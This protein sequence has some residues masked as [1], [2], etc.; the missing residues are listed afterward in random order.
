MAIDA[1][2]LETLSALAKKVRREYGGATGSMEGELGPLCN[3]MV[4]RLNRR[5][6]TAQRPK[7]VVEP[8]DAYP[9]LLRARRWRGGCVWRWRQR[10]AQ[11]LRERCVGQRCVER[12]RDGRLERLGGERNVVER[13]EPD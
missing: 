12:R 3:P 8:D 13:H 4:S 1:A 7:R 10:I 2:R 9:Y 11:R 5:P 6:S